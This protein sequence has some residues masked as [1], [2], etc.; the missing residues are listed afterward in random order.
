MNLRRNNIQD[1]SYCM[2]LEVNRFDMFLLDIRLAQ[3]YFEGTYILDYTHV[4][5]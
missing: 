5:D 2:F 1:Y 4:W 3:H